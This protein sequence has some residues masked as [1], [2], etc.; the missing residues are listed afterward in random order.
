MKDM[1]NKYLKFFIHMILLWMEKIIEKDNTNIKEA[2][3]DKERYKKNI[4]KWSSY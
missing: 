3:R 2:T 1:E 4:Q